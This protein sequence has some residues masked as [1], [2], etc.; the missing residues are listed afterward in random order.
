MKLKV[1][2]WVKAATYNNEII[3]GRVEWVWPHVMRARVRV[4]QSTSSRPSQTCV[5]DLAN[6]VWV[7]LVHITDTDVMAMVDLALDTHDREW[8]NDLTDCLAEVRK[9]GSVMR[10]DS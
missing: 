10:Y 2:D 9:R 4:Y 7:N 1:G 6:I 8:F 3:I 5:V